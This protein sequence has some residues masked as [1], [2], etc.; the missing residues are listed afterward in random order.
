MFSKRWTS[1]NII[2]E[3]QAIFWLIDWLIASNI[4][5][6]LNLAVHTQKSLLKFRKSGI[7]KKKGLTFVD[8]SFFL[9]TL[10]LG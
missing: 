1:I 2:Y 3:I 10:N 8:I 5:H 9:V 4:K 7:L 6:F